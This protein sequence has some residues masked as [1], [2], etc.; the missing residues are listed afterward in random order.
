[1]GEEDM[2]ADVL[3]ARERQIPFGFASR[4]ALASR[5]DKRAGKRMTGAGNA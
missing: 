2:D 1:V 3:V 4:Q 5:S